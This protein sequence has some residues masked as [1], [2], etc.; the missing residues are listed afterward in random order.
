MKAG[1]TNNTKLRNIPNRYAA[2]WD[3]EAGR[4]V[5]PPDDEVTQAIVLTRGGQVVNPRLS[6]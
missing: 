2:Y 5:L 6:S 4:P 1:G 3:K